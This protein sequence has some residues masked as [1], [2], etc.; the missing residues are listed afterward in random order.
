LKIDTPKV[1]W[2]IPTVLGLVGNG[3]ELAENEYFSTGRNRGAL[4]IIFYN[5][6]VWLC[7]L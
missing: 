2:S 4:I 6:P 3:W 5:K 7:P 1:W